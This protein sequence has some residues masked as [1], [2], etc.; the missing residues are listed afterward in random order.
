MPK[1][2]TITIGIPAYNEEANIANMLNSVLAQRGDFT[3]E[4]ILV[5][6]D[7]CEDNTADIIRRFQRRYKNIVLIEG[8]KRE[9]KMHRL[10]QIYK[11][12]TSDILFTFDADIVL[13]DE[14]V[15]ENMVDKFRN[16]EN[17]VLVAAHQVPVKPTNFQEKIFY[18]AYRL[19]EE[20]R[21][22]VNGGDHIHNL[23]GSASA[24]RKDLVSKLRYPETLKTDQNFLYLYA[25]K[26]GKFIYAYQARIYY[27]PVRT[28]EDFRRLSERTLRH[29]QQTIKRHLGPEVLYEYKIPFRFK[30][31]AILRTLVNRPFFTLLVIGVNLFVRAF[32]LR[33]S[34]S[35]KKWDIVKTTKAVIRV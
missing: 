18:T 6:C 12:N 11:T 4:K 33:E 19:W 13:S 30:A 31:R 29:D 1:K 9:G 10:N 7:G 2:P 16:D 17:V 24:L 8:A 14:N 32:P 27:R 25:K 20:A 5:V 35:S 15:V 3:V 26:F 22:Y 34:P 23:Q 28:F 21:I